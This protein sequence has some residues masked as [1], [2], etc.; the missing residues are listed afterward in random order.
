MISHFL[1]FNPN[2]TK[3]MGMESNDAR[4][5]GRGM[6]F[7]V[8]AITLVVLAT[9]FSVWGLESTREVFT[10]LFI[11]TFLGFANQVLMYL[12]I[13]ESPHGD[14]PFPIANMIRPLIPV[15]LIIIRALTL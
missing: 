4:L 6:G 7:S 9:L 15:V 11:F 10:V 3:S 14:K 8:L 1:I 12:K 13:V 2:F 5:L